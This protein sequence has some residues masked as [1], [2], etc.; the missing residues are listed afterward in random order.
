[1]YLLNVPV[2]DLALSLLGNRAPQLPVLL[3]I[4]SASWLTYRLL[5]VPANT[6]LRRLGRRL[7]RQPAAALAVHPPA[8]AATPTPAGDHPC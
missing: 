8:I 4:L 2:I 1:M 7:L 6:L 5:E 3:A